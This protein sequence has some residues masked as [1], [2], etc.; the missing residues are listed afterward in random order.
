MSRRSRAWRLRQQLSERDL[1]ILAMLRELR[2]MTGQQVRRAFCP[3]G[4]QIT[5]ARKTRAVLKRLIDRKLVVRLRRRVGG[6]HAGSEGQIVGL[7][8]LGHAVLDVGIENARRHRSITNTKLAHQEHLLAVATLHVELL[9]RSRTGR[10]ELLEFQAEP[11]AWRRFASVGGHTVTLKPDA[12][13]RLAVDEYEVVAFIEQD[14]A[15]ESVPTIV[16]KLGVHIDYWRS[17]QEQHEHGVHPR[18]WW[19]V[20]DTA[21]LKAI[22]RAIRRVPAET[23]QLFEVVLTEQAVSQ[24]TQLPNVGG[25]W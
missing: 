20:P 7:S 23:R 8:G 18:V 19:L 21:R 10:A 5:Q 14:M 11:A 24:L 9:E 12:F 15:T 17:G 1:A 22:A 25:V 13:V 16:R 2:L 6:L 3:D 4:N